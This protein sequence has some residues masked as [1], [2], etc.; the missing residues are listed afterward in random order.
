MLYPDKWQEQHDPD[1]TEIIDTTAATQGELPLSL[2]VNLIHHAYIGK[3]YTY[4][5]I[6]HF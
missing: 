1:V 3:V 2:T 6:L 5:F 4:L